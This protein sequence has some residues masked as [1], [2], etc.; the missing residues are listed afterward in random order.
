MKTNFPNFKQTLS[1]PL[2]ANHRTRSVN[3]TPSESKN[4][5]PI[6]SQNSKKFSFT[7]HDLCLYKEL[8]IIEKKLDSK[9]IEFKNFYYS[10]NSYHIE[11][12]NYLDYLNEIVLCLRSKDSKLSKIISRGV[13]GCEKALKKSNFKPNFETP[14][15][16]LSILTI[17]QDSFSQ[18]EPENIPEFNLRFCSTPELESIKQLSGTLKKIKV[19]RITGQLCDLY[20][21]LNKMYTDIPELS[22]SPEPQ[23]LEYSN[24][25]RIMNIHLNAMRKNLGNLINNTK[26]DFNKKTCDKGSQ[27]DILISSLP[28]VKALENLVHEKEFE[29]AKIKKKF[30]AAASEKKALEENILKIN[31]FY[32]EVGKQHSQVEIDAIQLKNKNLKSETII[33][34][35]EKKIF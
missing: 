7:K 21:S 29:V 32:S 15:K 3:K 13:V 2:S 16:T 17:K 31:N 18:T 26:L 4:E 24:P 5:A 9:E 11:V 20:E 6:E 28:E 35:Q 34:A 14:K 25:N 8:N 30:E 23:D 12:K 27:N 33:T 19:S 22:E 10:E 1:S